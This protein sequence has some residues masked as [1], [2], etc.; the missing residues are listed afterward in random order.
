MSIS[1]LSG[2][3]SLV[4]VLGAHCIC[5]LVS[6]LFLGVA[7]GLSSVV[8]TRVWVIAVEWVSS[9]QCRLAGVLLDLLS[10]CLGLSAPH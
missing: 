5:P 4:P 10:I 2:A 1:S 6:W 8:A 9:P 3:T 7:W